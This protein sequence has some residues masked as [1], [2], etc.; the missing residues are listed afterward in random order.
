MIRF[1]IN[2]LYHNQCYK[3]F[4]EFAFRHAE[5]CSLIVRK[6]PPLHEKGQNFL[7]SASADLIHASD[8]S[9]WPG[10]K[11][12]SGVARVHTFG[13]SPGFRRLFLDETDDLGGWLSPTLPEDP[14][15]YRSDG[16]VLFG[17][18]IH[19]RDAF[20]DLTD[21]E[22]AECREIVGREN[23]LQTR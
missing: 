11:L 18:V 3:P 23:L 16:S 19:E 2:G 20:A 15:F 8:Q 9:E 12:I 7:K 10:T 22:A 13:L 17:S 21:A 6:T 1:N 14:A 5:S 4:L